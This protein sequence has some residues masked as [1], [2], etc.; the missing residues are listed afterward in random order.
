MAPDPETPEPTFDMDAAVGQV[1][2]GL[3]G[4]TPERE[5]ETEAQ[6][7]QEGLAEASKA[8][9][10]KAEP[11]APQAR[12]APKSWA[13]EKHEVWAKMPPEA[14]NYYLQR[15]QQMH[16]GISQYKGDADFGKS[17][18]DVFTPYNA[19]LQAAGINEAQA[20][21]HL[22]SAHAKLSTAPAIERAAYFAD[23]AQQ[24]G[25]DL[26]A[27]TQQA[28]Y[29]VDPHIK[30]LQ[31]QLN[32]LQGNISARDH[33]THQESVKTAEKEVE[34]FAAD[35]AHPYFDE[36]LDDI[37]INIRAGANLTDAYDKAIWA[38]P[39]TRAK[40]ISRLQ[41]EQEKKIRE[42]LRLD[43]L[44]ARNASSAT[45]RSRDTNAAPTE[46]LGTMED[47]M[48]STLAAINSR[49]H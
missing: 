22:L 21:Q 25:V 34:T 35:K 20:V 10:A 5:A 29:P 1:A 13:K 4:D 43:G 11:E 23:L 39:M 30:S 2:E 31:E 7:G 36:V 14:Q 45:V 40:E 19:L 18:R 8:P 28:A 32:V 46:P 37:S 3:F 26:G 48:R 16:E 17:L 12:A 41:T 42:N 24:Y 47:T 9:G 38:N 15:E 49:A 6:E 27:V 44:K 33:A